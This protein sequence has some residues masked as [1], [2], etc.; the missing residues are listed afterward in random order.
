MTIDR[1]VFTSDIFRPNREGSKNP[2][3]QNLRWLAGL[4]GPF[5]EEAT[6]LPVTVATADAVS[7]SFGALYAEAG[8]SPDLDNWAALYETLPETLADRLSDAFAT[9]LVIGFEMPPSLRTL[10]ARRGIPCVDVVLHPV[11]Y[12]ADLFF[13]FASD[14][15]GIAARLE[16]YAMSEA[17]ARVATAPLRAHAARH[18]RPDLPRDTVLFIGQASIDRSMI[19]GGRFLRPADYADRLVS[20]IEAG[21]VHDTVAARLHP[22]ERNAAVL[23][24]LSRTR[25]RIVEPAEPVYAL[26]SSGRVGSVVSLSSSVGEEARFFGVE[27]RYGLALSTP[28]R[29]RES[30]P[31]QP[32]HVSILDAYLSADFWRDCLAPA[33]A[34]GPM[35]GLPPI[36]RP[37]LLRR[38]L[39]GYW[40]YEPFAFDAE[41]HNTPRWAGTEGAEGSLRLMAGLETGA[42]SAVRRARGFLRRRR[43]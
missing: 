3:E 36:A 38:S 42:R 2:Q 20:L 7:G 32:G 23:E 43:D 27:A 1:I 37:D 19:S 25:F 12:M 9:A 35:D 33:V 6:G 8:L 17:A 10:L 34:V 40:G 22:V 14:T 26:L 28:V 4:L 5:V 24:T 41:R 11:R 13:G 16:A 39:R 15:P 21:A 30:P 18:A 29:Y 31:D